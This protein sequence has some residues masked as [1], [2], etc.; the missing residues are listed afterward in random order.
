VSSNP[1]HLEVYSIQRHVIKFVID[2]RQVGGFLRVLWYSPPIKLKYCWKWRWIPPTKPYHLQRNDK[3]ESERNWNDF[4]LSNKMFLY[5]TYQREFD[6]LTRMYK[7]YFNQINSL[8]SS[9]CVLCAPCCLCVKIVHSQLP[10]RVSL[11][12]IWSCDLKYRY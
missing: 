11:T 7:S 4:I 6:I 2:L 8:L 12:F 5:S 9:F 1:F 10:L 3:T